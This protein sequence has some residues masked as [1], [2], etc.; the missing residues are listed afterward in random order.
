MTRSDL[1]CAQVG[2]QEQA[3]TGAS[4]VSNATMARVSAMVAGAPDDT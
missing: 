4:S 3:V 2:K 1:R